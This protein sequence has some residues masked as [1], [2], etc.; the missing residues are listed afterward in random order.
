MLKNRIKGTEIKINDV[1]VCVMYAAFIYFYDF[2]KV[3]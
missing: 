1:E 2:I 3:S